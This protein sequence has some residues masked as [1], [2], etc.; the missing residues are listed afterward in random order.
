MMMSARELAESFFEGQDRLKG[1]P[2]AELL[3][4]P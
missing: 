2:P 4:P 3:A 1:P